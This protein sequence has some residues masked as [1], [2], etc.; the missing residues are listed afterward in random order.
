ME[1]IRGI[2]QLSKTLKNP[3]LTIGN[4]DGVHLGHQRIIKTAIEQA[5]NLLRDK[6]H[7]GYII[8]LWGSI[9]C[10]PWTRWHD[11]NAQV[12]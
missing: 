5:L 9:P 7:Q 4:F 6:I 3:V 12:W 11:L 8:V 2:D 1:V 10:T